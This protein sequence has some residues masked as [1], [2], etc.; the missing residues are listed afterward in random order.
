MTDAAKAVNRQTRKPARRAPRT[1]NQDPARLRRMRVSKRMSIT[2]LSGRSG[3][4]VPYIWQLEQGV[5]SASPR[6]LGQLADALGCDITDIMPE[7]APDPAKPL[8]AKS[9]AA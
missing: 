9:N 1:L 5:Y 4:S 3:V 6:K 2:E 7:P 8:T